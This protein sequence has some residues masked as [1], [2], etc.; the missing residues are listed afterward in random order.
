MNKIVDDI[1]VGQKRIFMFLLAVAMDFMGDKKVY[2]FYL[3][4]DLSK[5]LF[6]VDGYCVF[7]RW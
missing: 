5:F 6:M 3:C 2:F 7:S 1:R 4:L